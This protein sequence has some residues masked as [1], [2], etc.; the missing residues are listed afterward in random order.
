MII[1]IVPQIYNEYSDFNINLVD[2][3]IPELALTLKCDTDLVLCRP[4][5]NKN[6]LVARRKQGRKAQAG[7]LVDTKSQ[8]SSFSVVTRWAVNAETVLVHTA[9]HSVLDHDFGLVTQDPN[10][11]YGMDSEFK[12]RWPEA[13]AYNYSPLQLQPT[14]RFVN[15]ADVKKEVGAVVD[16]I[17]SSGEFILDR[18]ETLALPSI[19]PERLVSLMDRGRNPS[20]AS[21]IVLDR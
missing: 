21:A 12:S 4:Y 9:V 20:L 19:E 1:H 2:V 6:Y 18:R 5:P 13:S 16:S 7:F 3:S 10:L 11:W 14:M 8:L 17:S 15:N